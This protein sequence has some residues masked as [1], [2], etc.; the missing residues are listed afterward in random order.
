MFKRRNVLEADKLVIVESSSSLWHL[1]NHELMAVLE[2]AA[3]GKSGCSYA[4]ESGR[5]VA[6][7][8][9][10]SFLV[11]GSDGLAGLEGSEAYKKSMLEG[12][13]G[14]YINQLLGLALAKHAEVHGKAPKT[15][16]FWSDFCDQDPNMEIIRE[17]AMVDLPDLKGTKICCAV[18]GRGGMI[19]YAQQWA[20]KLGVQT[21]AQCEAVP[22][23][24]LKAQ[25]E[26]DVLRAALPKRGRA[27]PNIR[28]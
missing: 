13:G 10:V 26:A 21:G 28:V 5:G 6:S 12:G 17:A 7:S 2:N 19:E 22:F 27:K 8:T 16:I 18:D 25:W 4:I 24:S 11:A 3:D 9:A 23:E 14:T 1:L 20:E 15:I